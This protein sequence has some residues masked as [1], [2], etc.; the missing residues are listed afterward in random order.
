LKTFQVGTATEDAK[1]ATNCADCHGDSIM[2]L[3]ERNIHPGLFDPDY[4]KACHDYA[5][6]N[7]GNAFANQGGT[8]TSGWSGF[9]AAPISRRIHGVHFG[10]YLEHSAEIYA[11]ADYFKDVI[12]PQDVRNCTKCHANN[13]AWKEQPARVPCLACHDT[14]EEAKAHGDLMTFDLTP[15]DPYGGDEVETCVVCHGAD[16]AF[17]PDTVH[18]ISDP[19]R[20]PY[21]R[22]PENK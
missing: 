11:N 7:A 9:G 15:E 14:D 10:K 16:T 22:E 2:H 13:P 6:Y 19:Y 17:S 1:V 4:C 18:N 20:P 5:H 12:F 3:Y 8:S 21:P